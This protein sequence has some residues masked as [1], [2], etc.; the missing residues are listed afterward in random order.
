MKRFIN[1]DTLANEA[2]MRRELFKGAFL[3]VEGESDERLYGIFVDCDNCQTIICHGRENLFDTCRI[4]NDNH[5]AG[6]L[7]VADADFDHIEGREPP[8]A[9]LYYT[10]WHDAECM[11][12]RGAALDRII[13]QFT[14]RD[15]LSS[16]CDSY[17]RDV[18]QHLLVH[19][20]SVG[21]LLWH[22]N[23]N[24]LGLSF[25]NLEA[26]EY[27]DRK[28]LVVDVAK[29]VKHVKNKSSRHDLPDDELIEGIYE[30]QTLREDL[31]QIVRGHDV[32]D[33][34]G[35]AFRYAWG[36]CTAHDVSLEVLE[37][38]LRLAFPAEEFANTALFRRIR[39]WEK[40]NQPYLVLGLRRGDISVRDST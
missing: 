11:M 1:G 23:K 3:L 38:S 39:E 20:A 19:S 17:G 29:L 40:E 36:T 13:S 7:G 32:I 24:G 21:F 27:F 2:R 31:W 25:D 10:D 15:K 5:F 4:L 34:L 33:V 28:S 6:V 18:R 12:L 14:S 8:F 9:N 22:S 16:W 26:K 30:R 37:Q 35:Y